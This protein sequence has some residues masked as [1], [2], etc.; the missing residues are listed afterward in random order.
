MSTTYVT[1]AIPYVEC[2]TASGPRAPSWSETDVLARHARG[3]R[4]RP[5][6][7]S[8]PVPTITR[9]RTESPRRRPKACGGR[10]TRRDGNARRF[11]ALREAARGLS[12]DD[13]LQTVD[14]RAP[15][16]RGRTA[17]GRWLL[18]EPVICSAGAY[19]GLFCSGCEQFVEPQRPDATECGLSRAPARRRT[20]SRRGQLVLPV[21]ALRG[22]VARRVER[23]GTVEGG[24]SRSAGSVGRCRVRRSRPPRLQRVTTP[25][26]I[27]RLGYPSARRP[28]PRSS[29][30]G[31]TPWSTT[32]PRS[33]RR[34]DAAD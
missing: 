33:G 27:R 5:W 7:A 10:D 1:V 3:S 22:A 4:G 11:A 6:C 12:N 18:R 26:T 21:V 8:S 25:R 34:T 17:L 13:F 30:C 9:P 32:S 15:P 2:R 14:R 19:E 28:R 16:A 31:S 23:L 20:S 24:S 29:T